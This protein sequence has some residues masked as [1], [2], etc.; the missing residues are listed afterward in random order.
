MTF[1]PKKRPPKLPEKLKVR[2]VYRPPKG[3]V[4][5][6]KKKMPAKAPEVEAERPIGIREVWK[7]LPSKQK[8]LAAITI[9]VVIGT[10]A[11]LF[12]FLPFLRHPI[13]LNETLTKE[14]GGPF[15]GEWMS[16]SP[17]TFYLYEFGKKNVE[18]KGYFYFK[19][20]QEGNKVYT[21]E[22]GWLKVTKWRYVPG[23]PE[24]APVWPP[25]SEGYHEKLEKKYGPGN[26]VSPEGLWFNTHPT[27]SPE[28]GGVLGTRPEVTRSGNVITVEYPSASTFDYF[29]KA[30][31]AFDF[32]NNSL[33]I[34]VTPNPNCIESMGTDVPIMLVKQ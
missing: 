28:E 32:T 11:G 15:T 27:Y 12:A 10:F 21:P 19:V 29:K 8:F 34:T 20:M 33:Y 2:V 30:V 16:T 23:G 9:I 6:E 26:Y 14:G 24:I 7:I 18:A 5:F 13:V 22:E 17:Q 25:L 31:F 1:L 4:E 3:P